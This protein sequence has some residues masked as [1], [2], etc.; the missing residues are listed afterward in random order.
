M[1]LR[2][3]FV[4]RAKAPGS[5]VSELCREF[6][7]S[8][9]S[10]YKWLARYE[11]RGVE[12]LHDM[13]RRPQAVIATSG[14]FVLRI[15]EMKHAHPRWGPK[16][17]HALLRRRDGARADIPC[18]RT[19][20]RI[21]VR[22]GEPLVRRPRRVVPIGSASQQVQDLPIPHEPNDMW[23][24]D[25][26]GW[27][28]TLNGKKAEPLT[29]RDALSRFVLLA[30]LMRSTGHG[31][32][33]REFERLFEKHGVPSAI[34]VD[35]GPPFA[36]R[37][38]RCGLSRLS[39]WWVS[40]G[41]KVIRGRPAHPQDNGAHERMH[42]DMRWDVEDNAARTLEAQQRA[43]DAWVEEFN[44]V[45][46]HEALSMRTPAE[47]YHPSSRRYR[48]PRAYCYPAGF[49]VRK[50][51]HSG[52]IRLNG[53]MRFI[54]GALAGYDVGLEALAGVGN[55]RVWF[56]DM[57]LG[58]LEPSADRASKVAARTVNVA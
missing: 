18:V 22:A 13:S 20:A 39:A 19:I 37:R 3:E 48:G 56:Y 7:V 10:G 33:R 26:K 16:K 46:P 9:K 4:L 50:V 8:R 21:L 6:G 14:E 42:A 30:K 47:I 54:S 51:S 31:P 57:D 15:L 32:V 35:N 36:S 49:E 53:P 11:A 34:R 41:I 27:W 1:D 45:R 38:A 44:H 5:N 28:R 43:L 12:G 2:E 24:A 55:H 52:H 17:L 58:P 29:V 40:L 23:T 25:F